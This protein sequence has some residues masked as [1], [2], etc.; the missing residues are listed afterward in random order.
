VHVRRVFLRT[1][2]ADRDDQEHI[3]AVARALHTTR[4]GELDLPA[5]LVGRGWCHA[6][7]PECAA[8]PLT[9]VC[10]KDIEGAGHVTS[11]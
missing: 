4:P 3:V 9:D 1:H 2:L 10:P 11:G 8:C 6:G 7:I 5:W